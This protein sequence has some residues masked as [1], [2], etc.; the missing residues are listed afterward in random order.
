[1]D[2]RTEDHDPIDPPATDAAPRTDVSR[3]LFLG[4]IATAAA[5]SVAVDARA[6]APELV[7]VEAF[8]SGVHAA[9]EFQVPPDVPDGVDGGR[10]VLS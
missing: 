2:I 3:R 10:A 9:V 1:M 8:I 5:A 7:N 4:G 6:Q